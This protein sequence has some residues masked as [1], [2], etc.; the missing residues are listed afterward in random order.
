[1][2]NIAKIK[3]EIDTVLAAPKLK[4][5]PYALAHNCGMSISEFVNEIRDDKELSKLY[6]RYIAGYNALVLDYAFA[7]KNTTLIDKLLTET[8]VLSSEDSGN[9]LDLT[10]QISDS[11]FAEIEEED[12]NDNSRDS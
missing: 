10:L 3:E 5:S 2:N 11:I 6:N 7:N 12:K 4:D 1:M 8:G 9:D